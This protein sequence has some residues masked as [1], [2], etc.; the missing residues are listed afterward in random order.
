MKRL[1]VAGAG[2]IF[3]LARVW[4]DGEG[5]STHL[6]E[7]TM[8]EW[9]RPGLGFDGLIDETASFLRATLPPPLWSAG[10][11]RVTVAEAFARW[12]GGRRAGDGGR[13]PGAGAAG[14]RQAA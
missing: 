2:P 8:L 7:F 6:G 13:R 10:F 5:S 14:W 1:L 9:Y 4:R 3:Q 12:A 11:E